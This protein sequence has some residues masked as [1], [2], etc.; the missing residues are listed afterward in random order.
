MHA[1][2]HHAVPPAPGGRRGR[3]AR[4]APA[5]GRR[6]HA[7]GRDRGAFKRKPARSSC[8]LPPACFLRCSLGRRG[9]LGAFR[10]F[11]AA[12][13]TV[14]PGDERWLYLYGTVIIL[15]FC[16]EMTGRHFS[17]SAG[18]WCHICT[19]LR[20]WCHICTVLRTW[21]HISYHILA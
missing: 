2:H 18:A 17:D 6:R 8:C 12:A 21:C 15:I 9:I 7:R 3:G 16:I 19:V 10:L 11:I 5:R 4:G 14:R 1:D 20:T 13:R